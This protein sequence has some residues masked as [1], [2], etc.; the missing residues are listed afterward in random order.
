[1]SLLEQDITVLALLDVTGDYKFLVYFVT[2]LIFYCFFLEKRK[3]YSV[4]YI[5]L[6]ILQRNRPRE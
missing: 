6:F 1:M 5:I 2:L 4:C 3:N